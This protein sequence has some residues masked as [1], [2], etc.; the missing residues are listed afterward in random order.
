MRLFIALPLEGAV[1]DALAK[2]RASLERRGV[3]GNYTREENL[4]L[5]LAFL[6][7][8]GDPDWVL[9]VMESVPLPR[10]RLTL[11]GFGAFA[12]VLWCGADGGEALESY[13]RALRRALSQADIPFDRKS[14]RPHITV[15]RKPEL[16][17]GRL[18]GLEVPAASMTA[19]RVV[20]F[21]SERGRNGM[22]YTPL[23][24]VGNCR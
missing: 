7:D 13:V 11:D 12:G 6:G 2:V 24:E 8:Y 22:V 23:G 14:F 5:T 4:H 10:F 19:E 17:R 1:L 16:P 3:R 18:P 20:L 21:R 9:E 15:L